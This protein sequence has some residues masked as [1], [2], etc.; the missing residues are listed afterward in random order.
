MKKRRILYAV[1]NWG[2]GHATRSLPVI[3]QLVK[4]HDVIILSTGRSLEL[5]KSEI[6]GADFIDH[7]DY[8][9]KY[10]N[11]GWSLLFSSSYSTA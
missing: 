1:L 7:P 6:S 11:K 8:S 5:L 10:S 4:E 2:L 9:V 3:R